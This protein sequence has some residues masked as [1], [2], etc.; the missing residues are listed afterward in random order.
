VL[1]WA[2]QQA[3]VTEQELA[4]RARVTPEKVLLWEAGTATPTVAKLRTIADMLKQPMAFFFTPAPPESGVHVP[5][6]FRG[7]STTAPHGLIQQ[8]R[9]AED[10]RDTFKLL[11]PG[12]V[13]ESAWPSWASAPVTPTKARE[14]LGV[15]TAMVKAT[16]TPNDALKLWIAAVEDQGVLVFQMSRIGDTDCS[17]FSLDDTTTPVIVLNGADAPQ[18]RIFTLIHE[19]GHL[20]DHS[21]GLCLLR[22]DIDRERA[23]NQFAE[24]VL[25][26]EREVQ[27]AVRGLVGVAAVALRR[28]NLGD[29][30]LGAVLDAM[31]ADTISV[32]D[33]T[34]YLGAKVSMIDKLGR[35]LAGGAS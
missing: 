24:G 34:Y 17:G 3:G 26:P 9:L 30:Y 29:R 28:R 20:I 33:A 13:A 4:K 2:R 10:R 32:A 12:L 1:T 11:A 6:D 16:K 21:G 8:I 35:E 22:E 5:P 19:L 18:R 23:C 31:D 25:L 14:R 27:D 7:V 15:T